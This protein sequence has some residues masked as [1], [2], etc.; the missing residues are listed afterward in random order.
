LQRPTGGSAGKA[1]KKINCCSF[2]W[3]A[4]IGGLPS[5]QHLHNITHLRKPLGGAGALLLHR[6]LTRS[7]MVGSGEAIGNVDRENAA[8]K[9]KN[10][11]GPKN[12]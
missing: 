8:L 12:L 6:R 10:S 3:A 4:P 2:K 11:W 1:G 5:F 9:N 7:R